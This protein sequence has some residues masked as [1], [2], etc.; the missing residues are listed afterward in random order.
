MFAT[1]AL[2]ALEWSFVDESGAML[3]ITPEN[4]ADNSDAVVIVAAIGELAK[5]PFLEQ[6]SRLV[7]RA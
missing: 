5:L 4:V 6:M 1:L 3:P 2:F 7:N